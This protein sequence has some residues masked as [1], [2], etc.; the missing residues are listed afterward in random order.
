MNNKDIKSVNYS[1]SFGIK[2]FWKKKKETKG[3]DTSDSFEKQAKPKDE[4]VDM[5]KATEALFS[6]E[7]KTSVKPEWEYRTGKQEE[8]SV[9]RGTGGVLYVAG[10]GGKVHAIDELNGGKKW[11]YDT[12]GELRHA[13]VEGKNGL[14]YAGNFEDKLYAFDKKTGK[15]KW[16][17]D[18]EGHVWRAPVI[19][20]DGTVYVGCGDGKIFAV[21]GDTGEKKWEFQTGKDI[22]STPLVDDNNVVYVAS[23]DGNLYALDGKTGEKKWDREVG[24]FA[25]TITFAPDNSI[26]SGSS[27]G[28]ITSL[29]KTTGKVKWEYKTI[30]WSIDAPQLSPDGILVGKDVHNIIFGLDPKTGKKL[31]KI[32]TPVSELLFPKMGEDGNLYIATS[33]MFEANKLYGIRA[34]DGKIMMENNIAD[35]GSG[36]PVLTSDGKV[37]TGVEGGRIQA[38]SQPETQQQKVERIS[39]QAVG[40]KESAV[41]KDPLLI[42]KEEKQVVI[43]GVK[44]PIHKKVS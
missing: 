18:T 14:L 36:R 7:T 11:E 29:D 35:K 10:R 1:G 12:G 32:N 2:P 39:K 44:V 42:V 34:K 41:K 22:R 37:V 38:F 23:D 31:W 43:G 13:P 25:S 3:I 4:A 9:S 16:T 20:K 33:K 24:S 21:N 17:F 15:E 40:K 6:K 19:G 26:V 30:D 27:K 5:K 28:K 8:V